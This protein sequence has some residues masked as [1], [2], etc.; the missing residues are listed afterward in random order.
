MTDDLELC[1]KCG[2]GNLGPTAEAATEGESTEPFR[3]T[4]D[5]HIYVCDNC[6][7]KEPKA[8]LKEY[9]PV[10]DNVTAKVIKADEDKQQ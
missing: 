4:S 8:V 2:K 6:G 10:S 3:E 5:M 7:H 9:I 1:P